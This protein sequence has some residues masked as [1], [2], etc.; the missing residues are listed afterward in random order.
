MKMTGHNI[1]LEGRALRLVRLRDWLLEST[2]EME[3]NGVGYVPPPAHVTQ[4]FF[5]FFARAL[6]YLVHVARSHTY[7]AISMNPFSTWFIW[8][9]AKARTCVQKRTLKGSILNIHQYLPDLA[10]MEAFS[11]F[12]FI[13][14][15]LHFMSVFSIELQSKCKYTWIRSQK[16]NVNLKCIGI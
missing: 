13:F 4:C 12:F 8:Q 11:L 15:F 3:G 16:L 1:R 14:Y 6:I 5:F 2:L 10:P 7:R 9:T